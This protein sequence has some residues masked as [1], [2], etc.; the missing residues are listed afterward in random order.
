MADQ[1]TLDR[2]QMRKKSLVRVNVTYGVVFIYVVM[3]C[4]FTLFLFMANQIDKGL[5]VFGSVATLAA[6]ITGYWFGS[7]GAGFSSGAGHSK[8][9]TTDDDETTNHDEDATE[10]GGETEVIGPV[11][12]VTRP[13]KEGVGRE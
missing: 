5:A 7:R 11:R 3:A 13:T 2:E 12:S 10:D 1:D 9:S 8:D 6:G 4:A